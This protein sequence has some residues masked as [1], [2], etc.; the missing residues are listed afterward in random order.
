MLKTRMQWH[1]ARQKLIAENVANANTPDFE[2]KDLAPLSV[3]QASFSV[4]LGVLRTSSAHLAASGGERFAATASQ[5]FE[6]TPSGNA[7]V[8]EDEMT[9]SAENQ[10]DYQVAVTLY[11]KSLALLKT[12]IGRA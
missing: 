8:L 7:V 4:F 10:T 2:G 3:G 9:K 12:A 1:E 11:A 6:A 5:A